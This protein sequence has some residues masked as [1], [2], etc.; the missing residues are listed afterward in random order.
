MRIEAFATSRK[1]NMPRVT[2]TAPESTAQP[3]RFQLDREVV[4]IGRGDE[5]DIVVE[6]GSVSTH[7]AE[8]RR[9]IGGYELHDLGSTN[10]IKLDG[11]RYLVIPLYHGTTVYLGDVAFDFSL[12]DEEQAVLLSEAPIEAGY[13]QAP[14]MS[15]PISTQPMVRV[16][17]E[18]R[19]VPKRH[20]IHVEEERG[21]GFLAALILLLFVAIAFGI[22]MAIRHQKDTGGSI[23]SHIE[24]KKQKEKASTIPKA[25]PALESET[26]PSSPSEVAPLPVNPAP[27]EGGTQTPPTEEIAPTPAQ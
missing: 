4:Q 3:Y 7:H 27:T 2:I 18:P 25:S 12:T 19:P 24:E 22:G 13:A 11:E 20:V 6:N 23:I 8:M 14:A 10:G 5:N 9:I 21:G 16:P 17:I 1:R 26:T 15:P